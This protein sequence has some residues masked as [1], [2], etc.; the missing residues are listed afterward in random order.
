MATH[1]AAPTD[2]PALLDMMTSFNRAE[3]IPWDATL[4][5]RAL[6]H[7]LTHPELGFV[8]V[9]TI[10]QRDVGYAVVTFNYDLEF[11]GRDAF[12]TELF[13][14]REHRRAGVARG[15]LGAVET[16]AITEGVHALHL[17]VLPDNE[18]ALRLYGAAGFSRSPR[19]MLTKRIDAAAAAAAHARR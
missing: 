7:L 14:R 12:V 11:A 2:V 15:L 10:G 16:S 1:R 3:G 8:L 18:R 13:V 9:A 19:L 17:L 5:E 4:V 6:R